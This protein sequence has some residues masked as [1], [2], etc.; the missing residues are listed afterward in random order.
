MADILTLTE[1]RGAIGLPSTDT[2]HDADLQEF[3][4]P[5]VTKVC[6]R[7]AGPIMQ[8]TKTWS[9]NGGEQAIALPDAP[10]VSV[11]SVTEIGATLS[12]A[13]DYVVDLDAGLVYRGTIYYTWPFIFGHMNVTVTYVVG[14]AA[15]ATQTTGDHKLAARII[16][17]DLWQNHEQG[18]RPQFGAPDNAGQDVPTLDGY[19]IPKDALEL[20]RSTPDA[21][22]F[23]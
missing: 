10:I 21:P 8:V 13:T 12:P 5:A 18:F 16:L 7:E 19:L 17:A 20:L 4:I 15:D 9:A 11:T 14:Y 23:A 3:Y 22:G 1:A 6:E 2:T